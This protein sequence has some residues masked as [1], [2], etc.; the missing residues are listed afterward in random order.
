MKYF[1]RLYDIILIKE[2]WAH[3]YMDESIS[4]IIDKLPRQKTKSIL[5]Y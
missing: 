3:P 4:I 5:S 2:K 1:L